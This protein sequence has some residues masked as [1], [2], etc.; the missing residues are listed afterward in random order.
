MAVDA[1]GNMYVTGSTRLS[2]FPVTPGLP[3][4]YV[5]SGIPWVSG[6]FLTKIAAS[7]DRIA[8]STVLS[9]YEKNCGCCSSCFTSSRDTGGAAVAVDAAGNAYMAGNTNTLDL[10]TTP[11]AMVPRGPG[12]FAVKVNA[13]GASLGYLTYLGSGNLVIQPHSQPANSA[14]AIAVDSTGNAFIAG[15][16]FDPQFA[17][18]RARTR[19][20]STARR[21]SITHSPHLPQTPSH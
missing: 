10:P 18:T 2:T 9:A 8:Y 20:T 15:S 1:A 11:G 7:G 13:S 12:A 16:T 3:A 4:G 14:A 19:H 6:A 17:A 21:A 5:S